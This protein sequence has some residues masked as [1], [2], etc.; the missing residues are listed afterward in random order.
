M[1]YFVNEKHL[2]GVYVTLN[3]PYY[4]VKRTLNNENIDTKMII[5]IDG[6]TPISNKKNKREEDCLFIGSLE[7]LSDISVAIDQ[8]ITAIHGDKFLFFD[9]INTLAIF[10]KHSTVERFIHFITQKLREWKV[11]GIIISLY[12]KSEAH[13]LDSLTQFSDA[14]IDIGG[15]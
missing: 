2:P 7:K 9:S 3:K 4:I 8:A 10:N 6:A 11:K 13:L 5:F 14:R 12:E 1:N 15:R